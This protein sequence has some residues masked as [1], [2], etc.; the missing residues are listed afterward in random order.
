MENIYSQSDLL[1]VNKAI[2]N[3]T[4]EISTWLR[5]KKLE[6]TSFHGDAQTDAVERASEIIVKHLEQT[7]VVRGYFSKDSPNLVV[8]NEEGEY[9]V[10]FDPIDG[11]TVIEANYAVASIFG[12]WKKDQVTGCT[13]RDLAGAALAIYGSRTTLLLYNS[14]S[15]V[16]EELTLIKRGSKPAKWI[17]TVPKFEFTPKARN[18]S[19]EGV[20]S[21]YE[22]PGYLKIF[23]HY[24]IQGYSIRYSSSMAV[25]CY[26]MF[27]KNSGIYISLET[28]AYGAKLRLIYELIPIA[29]LIEKAN[30]VATDGDHNILDIVI[31]DYEQKSAFIA[32]SKDEVEFVMEALKTQGKNIA[33]LDQQAEILLKEKGFQ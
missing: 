24:V 19:P 32:G 26:Q 28:L 11:G 12:I 21:C 1:R 16:V 14:H 6:N 29:F 31:E 10:T 15:K 3:S 13:G 8:K 4:S 27:I 2:L 18:F 25:D 30:G 22:D 7:E 33:T 5:T 20:K 23:Q 9:I 17:V